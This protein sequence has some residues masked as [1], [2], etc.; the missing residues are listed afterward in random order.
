ML[1]S[2]ASTAVVKALAASSTALRHSSLPR[3]NRGLRLQRYA[4]CTHRAAHR[5]L[6]NNRRPR[7]HPQPRGD[8]RDDL[9]LLLHLVAR[10]SALCG[11]TDD[12]R[13][14]MLSLEEA[15]R[16]VGA[17]AAGREREGEGADADAPALLRPS[18]CCG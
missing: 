4:V 17:V 12:D 6:A 7:R 8:H 15:N 2:C 9:M 3:F 1:R 18:C 14:A 11:R 10:L 5:C 13:G 16:A